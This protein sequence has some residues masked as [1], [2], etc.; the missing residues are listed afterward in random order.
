MRATTLA[1]L[2]ATLLV[3]TACNDRPSSQSGDTPIEDRSVAAVETPRP[4]PAELAMFAP[5]GRPDLGYHGFG[6]L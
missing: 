4:T 6:Y 1:T 5:S 3:T 2:C